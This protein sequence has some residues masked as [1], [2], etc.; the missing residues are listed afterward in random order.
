MKLA[1]NLTMAEVA[2]IA[3]GNFPCVG[4]AIMMRTIDITLAGVMHK[5]RGDFPRAGSVIVKNE[6]SNQF[7]CGGGCTHCCR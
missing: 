5:T 6:V 3:V 4:S 7:H 2:L 1:I